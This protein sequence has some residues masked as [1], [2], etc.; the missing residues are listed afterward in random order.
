[1]SK[2]TFIIVQAC[3]TTI[4]QP[5]FD[6]LLLK[7]RA[8][9]RIEGS[10]LKRLLS[11]CEATGNKLD[12]VWDYQGESALLSATVDDAG[13]LISRNG[14]LSVLPACGPLIRGR[15]LLRIETRATRYTPHGFGYAQ[16]LRFEGEN[17]ES[18]DDQMLRRQMENAGNTEII[19]PAEVTL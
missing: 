19:N 6:K 18:I 7:R 12:K 11:H 14:E 10:E 9:L 1:M 4:Y 15:A 5:K 17:I 3:M 2:P 16:L 13:V 8:H